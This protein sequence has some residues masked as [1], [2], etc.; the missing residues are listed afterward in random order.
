VDAKTR[1]LTA[2]RNEIPDRVPVAPD[3]SN[4]V[5][6]RLTGKPFWDIYLHGDP[7][8]WQAHLDANRR[9]GFDAWFYRGRLDVEIESTNE[10]THKI[11]ER[12]EDRIV[13]ETRVKNSKG[14]IDQQTVFFLADSPW[15]VS[16]WIVDPVADIAC[17][18]E[19][20]GRIAGHNTRTLDRMRDEIAGDY[21]LG[22]RLNYPGFH[23]WINFFDG[24]LVQIMDLHRERPELLEQLRAFHHERTMDLLE[25]YL[26]YDPDYVFIGASGTLTLAS[27][28]LFRQYGLPTLKAITEKCYE[29]QVPTLLHACGKERELVRICATET[30]LSC[31][32]PL[33][34][35]P[36]GDCVLSEIKAQ[37]GGR[38]ALMGNLH[39]T[40]VMLNGSRQDVIAAARQAIADAAGGGGFILSTGDQCGRDTPLENLEALVEAVE[41]YGDY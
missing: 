30:H 27:P 32:N 5:P 37:Y 35:P 19:S 12:R 6:C 3:I 29:H 33:E 9:F 24:G 10:V 40:D 1:F 17:Y 20:Q 21:A 11:V 13:R 14:K 36:M 34:V 2:L 25:R 4:M 28:A 7:P 15:T 16:K 8:L 22:F 18:I 39:T 31:I 41:R 23:Y 38:L 26:R